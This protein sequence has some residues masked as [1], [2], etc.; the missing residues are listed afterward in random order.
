MRKWRQ[1]GPWAVPLGVLWMLT[2]GAAAP[3]VQFTDITQAVGI[4]F[5]H[6]NS[7]TSN[8]YLIETMG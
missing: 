1:A 6:E 7:A 8:K 4:D 2:G 3:E 5:K